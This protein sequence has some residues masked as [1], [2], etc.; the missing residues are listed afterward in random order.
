MAVCVLLLPLLAALADLPAVEIDTLKG[1][2]HSGQLVGLDGQSVRLRAGNEARTVPMSNVLLLRFA[3]SAPPEAS[4]GP[5]VALVDGSQLSCRDFRVSNEQALLDTTCCGALE[6]P[7]S[8]VAH[9]R[10]GISTPKL[11]DAWSGLLARE[12]KGDLLVVRK[13]DVL[14]FL[15][16][17]AGDVRDKVGFLLEGDEM[18]VAREKVY[19]LIYRRRASGLPK[20]VCQATLAGGDVLQAAQVRFDGAGL[21]IKLASGGE[22]QLAAGLVLALDFSAGKI[23]Y[24]SQL[25][26]RD[27]KYVPFFDLVWEYRR[28]RSL[29]GNA[30]TLAGKSY[31]RGLAI[32]SKTTLRYRLG[33]E[34]SRLQAVAGI[35]DEVRS[36]GAQVRLTISGDG[37]PLFDAAVSGKDAPRPLDLDVAGVRDLEIVVDF[38][39]D[40]GAMGDRLD[41]ADARL[42]K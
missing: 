15:S 14:D 9:V 13:D 42:L 25:E 30:I 31:A 38:G 7:V 20:P 24:L 17:V 3:A 27:V 22:L 32:H 5:R 2:R 37:K 39:D 35:D 40:G 18:Q 6:L 36:V 41:L 28:D 1:D 21:N 33:E 34:F 8:R 12:A 23:V 10:F 11:D 19:G 26:P 4:P 16:G 29:D